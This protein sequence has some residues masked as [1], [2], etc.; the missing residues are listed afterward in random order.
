MKILSKYFPRPYGIKKGLNARSAE[1]LLGEGTC[2]T[3]TLEF[4]G[5]VRV[6]GEVVGNIHSPEGTLIIEK[7]ALVNA[8]ISVRNAL[9]NGEVVGTIRAEEKVELSPQARIDGDITAKII[10]IEAGACFEGNCKT[11]EDDKID[12]NSNKSENYK[13]A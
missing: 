1:A 10:K 2:V 4:R 12:I 6:E 11:A 9:I 8:D 5:I 3:G 7:K 13:L